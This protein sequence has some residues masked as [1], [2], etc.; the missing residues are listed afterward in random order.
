MTLPPLMWKITGWLL[1]LDADIGK[2]FKAGEAAFAAGG[3][4]DAIRDAVL[5]KVA[6][7]RLN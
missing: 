3:N 2:V 5:A 7:I 4:L 6:E 1:L